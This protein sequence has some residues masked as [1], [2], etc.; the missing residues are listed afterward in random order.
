MTQHHVLARLIQS[1]W[2][3]VKLE[4]DGQSKK[5]LGVLPPCPYGAVERKR[6]IRAIREEIVLA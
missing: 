4:P 2:L 1:G 5:G 3:L 6:L